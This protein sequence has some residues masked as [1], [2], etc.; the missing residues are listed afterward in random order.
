MKDQFESIRQYDELERLL[1]SGVEPDGVEDAELADSL[2]VIRLLERTAELESMPRGVEFRKRV[3]RDLDRNG[4]RASW[5]SG[6]VVLAATLLCAILLMQYNEIME[7]TSIGIDP[8]LYAQLARNEA[9]SSM[10]T[11]LE[12]TEKLLMSMRDFEVSCSED[13]TDV[14]IEKELA[15]SLLTK[16]RLLT[17]QMDDPEF[18]RAR[19]LFEQLENVLVDVNT[20]DLCTDP[21]EVEILNEHISET[22]LLSK[23]RLIAQDIQS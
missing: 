17:A 14:E 6:A 13:Q 22:R 20:M 12:D 16:Q 8:K 23:V 3:I 10:V 7:E 4:R 2:K 15:K 1:E 5:W 19:H 9:R 21:D 18:I 11:Y